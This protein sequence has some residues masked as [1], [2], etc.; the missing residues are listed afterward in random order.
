MPYRHIRYLSD[1]TSGLLLLFFAG[2][3][4]KRE[5]YISLSLPPAQKK[6]KKHNT[7]QIPRGVKD[8]LTNHTIIQSLN[9]LGCL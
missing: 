5:P 2:R 1:L 7:E 3:N 8:K 4:W 6:V 9:C